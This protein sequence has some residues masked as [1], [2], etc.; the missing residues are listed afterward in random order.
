MLFRSGF[1]GLAYTWTNKRFS[2]KPL[3]ERLDCCLVNVDWCAAF[4][5]SN[6]YNLALLHTISDHALILL[7]TDGPVRR[8]NRHFKFENWWLKEKDFHS[9]AK[10]I[11]AN[12][13][14]KPF[15][16]RTNHLARAL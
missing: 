5:V 15:T 7:S 3:Y 10:K 8:V 6:V 9:H 13:N 1:S 16:Q 11:W 12:S 14:R 4:P 2:S